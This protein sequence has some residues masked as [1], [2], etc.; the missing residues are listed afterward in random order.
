[1][2]CPGGKVKFPGGKSCIFKEKIS[3]NFKH[4]GHFSYN[5][6]YPAAVALMRNKL[7]I[8]FIGRLKQKFDEEK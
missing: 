5:R 6:A 8:K 3:H 1:L 2:G 7:S 4:L